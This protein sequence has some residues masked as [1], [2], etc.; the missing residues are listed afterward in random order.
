MGII[1][2]SRRGLDRAR[3]LALSALL[4]VGLAGCSPFYV[5]RAGYE[6]AKILSRR[7]PIVEVVA[8]TT[9]PEAVRE[10]LRLVLDARA[11]AQVSLGLKVGES[12]TTFARL[13]SDTLA[14]IVSAAYQ[15][16]FEPY[17]WWF[18][19]V[20]H[21]PYKGYFSLEKARKEVAT[22]QAKGFD[23]Y[24]RPTSAFSTLGWFNDPLV[25][26]LLRYDSVAL[27]GT[28]VH[29]LLHNTYYAPGQAMFNESLAEFV[30]SHG[31][32]AFMCSRLG[33]ESPGC[34]RAKDDWH[35]EMVF[36]AFLDALVQRLDS[37]YT[38]SSLTREEKLSRR[39]V[40]F[41]QARRDFVDDVQP[42]FVASTYAGFLSAPINNATLISRRLYYHRLDL[43]ERVFH[44]TGGDLRRTIDLILDAARA[45]RA[46]PYAGVERIVGQSAEFKGQS[47]E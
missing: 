9:T 47:A 44:S 43:F 7:R 23:A 26:P 38:D 19:I 34:A 36:G 1:G 18:P 46:D 24:V 42:R 21:V 31:A 15:D 8:D 45:N 30:G 39:E 40:I 17:T 29:E 13:D 10:K 37:V 4:A 25:S 3:S 32:I 41:A 6:E 20:G 16:H 27:A 33:E 28:V 14:H 11:F 2:N 22:L 5:L 12:Y 35:D